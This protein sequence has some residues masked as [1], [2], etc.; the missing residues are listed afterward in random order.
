MYDWANSAFATTVMATLFP[1]FFRTLALNAGVKGAQVTALWGYASAACMLLIAVTAPILGAAADC[2]GRRKRWLAAFAALGIIAT[3]S[4]A[5]LGPRAWR[6][7][8]LVFVAAN[9]GFAA[10]NVFYDSFLPHVA[11]PHEIDR[12]SARGYALGY[13][14]GGLLLVVNAL[15]VMMPY[16]FGMPGRDFAVRA[17][18]LSVAVWWFAFSIPFF[19]RVPEIPSAASAPGRN[20]LAQGF[21]QVWATFREIR[22]YRQLAVFLVAFWIYAD[23]ISTIIRMAT[24]Y[25]AEMGIGLQHMVI[26]LVITQ[27]TGIPFTMLFGSLAGRIGAKRSLFIA[28]GCYAVISLM[29]FFMRT[30][31]HFY[32]LAI[33][34]GMVQGGSQALSRSIFGS[35]VPKHKTSQFFGFFSTS[36]KF[37]GIAGPLLF[38]AVSQLTGNSR[39]GILSLVMFFVA[40]ACVLCFVDVEAGIRAA[41]TDPCAGADPQKP[42]S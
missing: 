37:A 1:P 21:R 10:A 4:S 2:A 3:A 41:T 18:F 24:V 6:T 29:G 20:P 35:M 30:A 14:G 13:L 5:F 23:G 8:G 28:L 32:V 11:G 9:L 26:A 15:W 38:G 31:A 16:R 42:G 39:L 33:L 27:F 7:A 17:S 40:G 22:R 25:G 12:V 34:V 19:R 36:A